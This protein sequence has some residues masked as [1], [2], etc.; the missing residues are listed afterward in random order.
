MEISPYLQKPLRSL[1]EVE[2]ALRPQATLHDEAAG[3][4]EPGTP[5]GG[6]PVTPKPEL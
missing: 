4:S 1:D 6:R 5:A 2:E 3:R